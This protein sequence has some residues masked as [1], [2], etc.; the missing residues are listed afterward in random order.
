M[1]SKHVL[2]RP[3]DMALPDDAD[4]QLSLKILLTF[5]FDGSEG[6]AS[7]PRRWRPSLWSLCRRRRDLEVAIAVDSGS[8]SRSWPA[9][10]EIMVVL[11]VARGAACEVSLWK[12]TNLQTTVL[13]LT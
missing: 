4:I 13:K 8:I 10:V 2:Q 9:I 12:T 1:T 11:S 6:G 7:R 3:P 5:D